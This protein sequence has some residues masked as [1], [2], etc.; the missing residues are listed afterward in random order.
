[1]NGSD[2]FDY[3][4]YANALAAVRLDF[5]NPGSNTGDAAGDTLQN[6][7][8]FYLTGFDDTFIGQ[9]GQ[10]IVFAGNGNDTLFGGV[11]ASD[12]LFGE[13]G[14]DFLAGGNFD[15]LMSGGVGMDTY[16]FA[17]WVGNGFDSILDFT[18]GLDR[19]QL[20]GAGFGLL[21]GTPIVNG[22]NLISAVSPF[23]TSSQ[24]TL[25]YATGLGILYYDPDGS[26][27]GAAIALAQFSGA[28]AIAAD[29]FVVV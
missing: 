6:F 2:G 13:S 20:T 15:D 9:T 25:L 5:T 3:A 12:W 17:S 8:A 18:S 1:M 24:G 14:N 29:D 11:N 16:A 7:E 21:A 27:A 19:I 4:S 10:N 28:P 23:A 26:G 22:V